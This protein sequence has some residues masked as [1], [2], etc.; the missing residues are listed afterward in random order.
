MYRF[1]R[2]QHVPDYFD[3]Q[4]AK[5]TG[6]MDE[7]WEAWHDATV[8]HDYDHLAVELFDVIHSCETALRMLEGATNVEQAYFDC[9][10]K[11]KERGYY[12]NA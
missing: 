10:Q 5:I 3:E 9:I 8:V 12:A 6:E 1:P 4:L 2:Y 11:N 7:V